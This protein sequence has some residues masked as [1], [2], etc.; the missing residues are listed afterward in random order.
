MRTVALYGASEREVARF[1][2]RLDTEHAVASRV[3]FFQGAALPD[4]PR[5]GWMK[6][7]RKRVDGVVRE[8]VDEVVPKSVDGVVRKWVDAVVPPPVLLPTRYPLAGAARLQSRSTDRVDAHA[9]P[10]QCGNVTHALLPSVR[11]ACVLR[12]RGTREWL[13][14]PMQH[15][16]LLAAERAAGGRAGAAPG[17]L[18]YSFLG[19]V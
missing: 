9:T 18:I 5:K 6:L 3:A 17:G 7:Y 14:G 12:Q 19:R 15:V 11:P 10:H 13:P 8:R 2:G 1:Q 4:S 16:A